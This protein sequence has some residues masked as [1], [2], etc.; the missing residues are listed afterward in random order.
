M[1]ITLR[2][3]Q[4]SSPLDLDTLAFRVADQIMISA[5]RD[6]ISLEDASLLLIS[7]FEEEKHALN[8]H[9]QKVLAQVIASAAQQ[10]RD[11]YKLCE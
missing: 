11:V 1:D 8:E 7:N 3:V 2:D 4:I 9:D 5:L 10:L 6:N